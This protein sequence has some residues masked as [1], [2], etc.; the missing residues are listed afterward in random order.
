MQGVAKVVVGRA[1][2]LSVWTDSLI[3]RLRLWF[4]SFGA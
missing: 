4:W 3:D 2:L 1:S